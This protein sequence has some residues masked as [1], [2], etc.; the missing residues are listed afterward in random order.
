MEDL[1][2]T[3]QEILPIRPVKTKQQ[4]S[5][6]T[7]KRNLSNQKLNRKLKK[8]IEFFRQGKSC[9]QAALKAGFSESYADVASTTIFKNP[10]VVAEIQ[11]LDAED[12]ALLPKVT[13]AMMKADLL[14][15]INANP[16][17]YYDV[18]A[19]GNRALNLDRIN[20]EQGRYIQKLYTD[21]NGKLM[22]ELENKMAARALLA[23]I[24]R[25]GTTA[26]DNT[27]IGN[28][29]GQISIGGAF[30]E[31]VRQITIN[32]QNNNFTDAR[33]LPV[34]TPNTGSE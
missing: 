26:T 10:A 21:S 15:V 28:E 18:D 16:L 1:I 29:E 19:S 7:I 20:R 6:A 4:F 27:I 34:E 13:V 3:Q 25:M 2:T 22:M 17:D 33:S 14:K 30:D 12:D 11:R 23:K 9:R 32:I 31:V 5:P 24:E 8:A